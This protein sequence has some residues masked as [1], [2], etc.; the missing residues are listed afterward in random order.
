MPLFSMV[1]LVEMSLPEKGHRFEGYCFLN[2]NIYARVH[3]CQRN[4][5]DL[6]CIDRKRSLLIINLIVDNI[7]LYSGRHKAILIP[8]Q[9]LTPVALAMRIGFSFP[10][11]YL[12]Y[13][14][15]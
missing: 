10:L 9:L 5:L 1:S 12:I 4:L 7:I 13:R 8:S 15:C 11:S 14:V 2:Q 3:R 6:F